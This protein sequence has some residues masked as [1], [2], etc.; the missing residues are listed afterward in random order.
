MPRTVHGFTLI[1][2]MIVVAIIA[3]LAAIA[4]PAYNSYRVRAAETACLAE[5]KNYANFSLAE[6][7]NQ[8]APSAA[9]TG[10]CTSITTATDINTPIIGTPRSPGTRATT[11]NMNSASCSLN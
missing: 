1:E 4:L 7:H 9:A 6:I 10:A 3:L 8:A 2:L 5:T 11:C